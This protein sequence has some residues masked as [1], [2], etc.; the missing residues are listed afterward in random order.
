MA[1]RA[2]S[3]IRLTQQ[4]LNVLRWIADGKTSDETASLLGVTKK[5]VDAH[6]ARS[7]DA[8][9]AGTRAGLVA[10]ALRNDI[11]K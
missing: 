10:L 3:D 2:R 11:I 4:Q 5:S 8:L 9:G 1:R 7:M 6:V